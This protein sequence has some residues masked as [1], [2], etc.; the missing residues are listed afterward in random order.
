MTNF[1]GSYISGQP[2]GVCDRCGFRKRLKDMRTEWTNLKVCDAC[3]DPEP[4]H[5]HTPHIDP[6]E[7]RPIPGAR[8]E[9]GVPAVT[10]AELIFPYRDSTWFD[11]EAGDVPAAVQ[12]LLDEDGSPLLDEDGRILY[13][14]DET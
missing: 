9:Q 2:Y 11:P 8:P 7:G 6:G 5:L 10:D 12:Q 3:Y 14:N 1:R 13:S 4:V